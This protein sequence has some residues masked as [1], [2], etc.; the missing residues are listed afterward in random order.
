MNLTPMAQL[1]SYRY[2][3]AS[4]R[5]EV[6]CDSVIISR[7]VVRCIRFSSVL[8][9]IT[10]APHAEQSQMSLSGS[11]EDLLRWVHISAN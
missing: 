3:S 4:S 10:C 8:L 6:L 11:S 7:C 2:S 1:S 5:S 9:S